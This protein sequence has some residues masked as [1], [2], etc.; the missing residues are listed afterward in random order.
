MNKMASVSNTGKKLLCVFFAA[1]LVGTQVPASADEKTFQ[2]PEFAIGFWVDPPLD[3]K[4]DQRYKEIAEAN[5]TLVLGGFGANNPQKIQQQ[6]EL[7]KKYGLNALVWAGKT[8]VDK[9]PTD[10]ACWGYM[11]LDEPSA[12]QFKELGEIVKR[13]RQARPD[14]MSFINLFPNYCG[15]SRLASK[16]YDEYVSKFME[17]VQPQVLCMDHYPVFK[18]NA[19]DPRPMYR[20]N[21]IS[22][23]KAAKKTNTPFWLFF[24]IMPYGPQT[25]PTEAQL[26][27]Q[28]Y[29]AVT[30]GAK[31]VLYFCYYT[32]NGAEFPKGGAIIDRNDKKTR[33]YDQAKRINSEL[34][35]LGPVLMKLTPIRVLHLNGKTSYYAKVLS[36][37]PLA[38]INVAEPNDP[39]LDIEIGVFKH[40][41]GRDAII[42]MNNY[43]TYSLW[44]TINFNVPLKNVVE[45][46]KQTGKEIPVYDESPDIPGLQISF[47][48]GE[49]RVFLI[50]K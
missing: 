13:N 35:N 16:D 15:A 49:G 17:I 1:F 25:D 21:L 24:N 28:I 45:I 34:K 41:D 38:S 11:I 19:A 12:S 50:N 31:G 20:A 48:S 8:P 14:K 2:Q 44:P 30:Y 40:K 47:D 29:T 3:A 42:I 4:A 39:Q 46:D 6:V 5:F 36:G 22:L 26:R 32:P 37:T 33:H 7:C 43:I 23:R 10:P 9:L 18:P 27:W